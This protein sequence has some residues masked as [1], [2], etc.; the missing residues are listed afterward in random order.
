MHKRRH[1][2][3][4]M[5]DTHCYTGDSHTAARDSSKVVLSTSKESL[6]FSGPNEPVRNYATWTLTAMF[7]PPSSRYVTSALAP[8]L[9][10]PSMAVFLSMKNVI[11]L[12]SACCCANC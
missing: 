11:V 12:G 9:S 2:R 3:C 7:L 1:P 6:D 8:T 10:L 5:R 4:W